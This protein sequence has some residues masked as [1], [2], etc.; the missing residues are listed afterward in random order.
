M[1]KNKSSIAK[2]QTYKEIGE[3]WDT[4][5]STEYDDVL[6]DVEMNVGIKR[7]HYLIEIDKKI[8]EVLHKNAQMEGISDSVFASKLLQKELVKMK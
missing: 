3:F 7:R 4:H 2:A 6:E 5:D 8:S 1:T